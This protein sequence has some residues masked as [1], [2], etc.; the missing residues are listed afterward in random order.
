MVIDEKVLDAL[1]A[2]AKESPRLRMNYFFH[3]PEGLFAKEG[4]TKPQV[5]EA[6]KRFF[7]LFE[8]EGKEKCL[9]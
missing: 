6:I 5:L 3:Q 9:D 1:T 8:H 4:V 7:P 2:R